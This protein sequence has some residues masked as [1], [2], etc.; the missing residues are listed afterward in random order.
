MLRIASLL[1]LVVA[2]A[3]GDRRQVSVQVLVPDLLGRDTPIA[4]VVVVALPYD[5]DSL[6]AAMESRAPAG[7]P[8]T[9]TLDTLFQAFHGPFLAF[10]RA[11]WD[12]EVTTRRRDSLLRAQAALPP[13]AAGAAELGARL[14]AVEDSLR[15]LAPLLART[16]A[17]LAD[18]RDALWPRMES[19][20]VAARAWQVSTYQGYDTA[21][22]ALARRK[23]RTLV[24]DT[25]GASGW[26]TLPIAPGRWWVHA[27]SPDPQDPNYEWYWNVPVDADSVRLSQA[28]GR[29]LPRY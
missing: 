1:L 4:G 14:A 19:L 13:G 21:V 9:E 18:A 20:R 7:R 24:A 17:D 3:C 22:R 29:H 27:R 8:H 10:N 15:I 16:R 2:L 26:S 11:A 23:M 12:Q 5:R 25:S 6:I 28:N